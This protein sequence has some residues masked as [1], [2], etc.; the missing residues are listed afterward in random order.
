MEGRAVATFSQDFLVAGGSLGRVHARPE[1][2]LSPSHCC[3]Q[4][5]SP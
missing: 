4:K 2:R 1:S 3:R 5:P